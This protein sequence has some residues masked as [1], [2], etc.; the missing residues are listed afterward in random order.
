LGNPFPPSSLKPERE[1]LIF[2]SMI[3][4]KSRAIDKSFHNSSWHW[5]SEKEAQRGHEVLLACY[6]DGIDPNDPMEAV[7]REFDDS[8]GRDTK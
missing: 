3:F 4:V 6:W 2:E 7:R 1:P 8:F 5:R